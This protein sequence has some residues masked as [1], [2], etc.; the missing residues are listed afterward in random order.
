L[1]FARVGEGR[2]LKVKKMPGA[3]EVFYKYF[4]LS[5]RIHIGICII[6]VKTNLTLNFFRAAAQ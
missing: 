5:P 4:R 3:A 2:A 6:V 1:R